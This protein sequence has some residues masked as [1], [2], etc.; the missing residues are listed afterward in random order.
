MYVDA[1]LKACN[2]SLIPTGGSP[3]AYSTGNVGPDTLMQVQFCPW[4]I[5]AMSSSKR[6]LLAGLNL[7]GLAERIAIAGQK[8][9]GMS[10][11]MDDE[12]VFDCMMLHEVGIRQ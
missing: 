9:L 11:A 8:L 7:K 2:S 3:A 10:T 6:R 12:C 4:Y 1:D 5:G